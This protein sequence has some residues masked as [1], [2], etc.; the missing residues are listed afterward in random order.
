MWRSISRRLAVQA[1]L[2]RKRDPISKITNAERAGGVT[3]VLEAL[4]SIPRTAKRKKE[5]RGQEKGQGSLMKHPTSHRQV[6][7]KQTPT[8]WRLR[9]EMEV[10]WAGSSW[11]L[12]LR[13]V[14]SVSP[15]SS[16]GH[17]FSVCERL[18]F[19]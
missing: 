5:E 12:F 13:L 1:D 9:S 16:R 3:Q 2:G 10:S 19:L 4:S 18:L 17:P 7:A 15:M 6:G 14:D 8:S 11:V